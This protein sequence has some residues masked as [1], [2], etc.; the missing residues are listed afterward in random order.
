M[1]RTLTFRL[2]LVFL[3]L[4]LLAWLLLL[5]DIHLMFSTTRANNTSSKG[6]FGE[7]DPNQHT[8]LYVWIEEKDRLST[9]LRDDLMA[10]L[11]ATGRFD[12]VLLPTPKPTAQ[13]FPILRVWIERP[14][15]SWTPVY[16]QADMQVR[17]A[18][19]SANIDVSFDDT[20]PFTLNNLQGPALLARGK[21]NL[22]DR[23][24][25]LVSLPGYWNYLA[26]QA[27]KA[28]QTELE[29]QLTK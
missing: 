1:N 28:V 22:R 8:R 26:A 7:F 2:L 27:A 15:Y 14:G 12:P 24:Y 25:G 21:V 6:R 13:D 5:T 9:S 4:L 20:R 18:F 17:W 29:S 3:A 11:R 23:T 16:A 19:S 10:G